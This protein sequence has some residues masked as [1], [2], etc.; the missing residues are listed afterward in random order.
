M[1]NFYLLE[2]SSTHSKGCAENRQKPP[3]RQGLTPS[4]IVKHVES[5]EPLPRKPASARMIRRLR[6]DS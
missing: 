2:V 1:D 6:F 3:I 4:S 5:G